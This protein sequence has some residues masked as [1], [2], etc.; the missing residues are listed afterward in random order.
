MKQIDA[1]IIGGGHNG[2]VCA[3]YL[4]AAGIRT[5][6]L[7]RRPIVG[8]AAVTE[9]F[10]PGFRNSTA[11]YTVSLLNPGIIADLRLKEHGLRILERPFS[12]FLPLQDGNYLRTGA[13]P[14][15]TRDQ[16]ARF[17]SHDAEQLP[18]Y[19]TM[20]E[21]AVHFLRP[22][23]LETPPN[24]RGDLR[25]LWSA[26]KTG[27]RI[28]KLPLTEMSDL[29]ALFTRS[30]GEILDGWFESDP[31]KA[32]FGFDAIVGNFTSPYTPGCAYV[33]LHHVSGEVNGKTGQWGHAVGGMG[34]ITQAIAG[35]ARQAGVRIRLEA[36]VARVIMDKGR[37]AGVLLE[38]GEEIRAACVI[39]NVNPSLLYLNLMDK[40]DVDGDFYRRISMYKNGSGTFRMNVALSELPAFDCAPAGEG[41]KYLHSGIIIAP[42]LA[43][44]DQAYLDARAGGWAEAPVIEMLVP[45]TMDNTLAPQGAHVA[46][47][48]CQHF[49]PVLADGRSWDMIKEQVADRIIDTV[50][51]YAPNFKRSILGRMAL[52]PLDLEN[53]FGLTGGDIFHGRM[54]LDQLYSARPLLGYGAYR[55]PVPG[56]YMCG[57]GTHPGGGVTGMP[58]HNAAREIIRDFRRGGPQKKHA[59]GI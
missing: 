38:N 2:L 25:G 54:S 6:I 35:A 43:Y 40:S 45:S 36:P 10:Y 9:E 1:V 31:I 19:F 16:F 59:M 13:T 46:S 55:G 15:E 53:I 22:L 21:K 23:A 26:V 12:N 41:D 11:S 20:L 8:G 58:G 51:H 56:L 50:D 18:G 32:L 24:A 34:A 29:H 4:A 28:R 17:S 37:A 30:A 44:M 14:E 5:T 57:S 33:L 48:F 49:N 27:N 7:E 3:C 52:S 39:A 47:L 42:S